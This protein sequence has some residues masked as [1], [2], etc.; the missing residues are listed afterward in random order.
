MKNAGTKHFIFFLRSLLATNP[1]KQDLPL[2][3]CGFLYYKYWCLETVMNMLTVSW[4]YGKRNGA[5]EGFQGK[6]Q[7]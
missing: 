7:P 3:G 2:F 5:H 6:S 1:H 4:L